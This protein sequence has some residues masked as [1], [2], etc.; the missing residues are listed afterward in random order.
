VHFGD[1]R[2][3]DC[4]YCCAADTLFSALFIEALNLGCSEALR[5]AAKGGN[6]LISD[7]FPYIG[8]R[9]Y[10]PKPMLSAQ[11]TEP[12]RGDQDDSTASIQK[13]AFKRLRHIPAE[14]YDAYLAGRLDPLQVLDGFD[15]GSATLHTK[16]NLTHENKEYAEPYPVGCFLFNQD[17]GLYFIVQ[18]DFDLEPILSSLQYSG[19]GGERSSGY[20][21]FEYQTCGDEL[22][23][24]M[25]RT[26]ARH[27]LLLSSAMPG[28]DEL[29][30]DLLV[31]ARYNLIRRSGFVQSTTYAPRLQKKR[32]FCLFAAGSVFGK[33]FKGDV[34]DV[35]VGTVGRDIAHPV[36]RY[37]K[38][39]WIEVD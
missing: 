29:D 5:E 22:L 19:I 23:E 4:E 3:S 11:G 27:K 12:A 39:M 8:D 32:D 33:R 36:W 9:Y 10:L 17:A 25:L 20:G 15:L 16:V 7:L 14:S 38:A 37:A 30:D 35:S 18:G 28:D 26:T 1:G 34:F 2:L 21:R 6:L 31:D 13:K 24:Q